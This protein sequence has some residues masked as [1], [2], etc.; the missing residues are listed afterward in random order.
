LKFN[1]LTFYITK[2]DTLSRT[3][4]R[5]L[6]PKCFQLFQTAP[7]RLGFALGSVPVPHSRQRRRVIGLPKQTV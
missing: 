5:E 1:R 6:L 7:E 4:A 3:A 2:N